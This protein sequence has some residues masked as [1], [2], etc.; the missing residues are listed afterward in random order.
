MIRKK[1]HLIALF[2]A[3]VITLIPLG[4]S[5]A[6]VNPANAPE[7]FNVELD[8]PGVDLYQKDYPYGNPDYVQV[9]DLG[10]GASVRILHT[11]IVNL[12]TGNGVYGG[13]NPGFKL[14]PIQ[15]TWEEFAANDTGAFCITNGGYFAAHDNPTHLAFPIKVGGEIVSDGYSNKA[16]TNDKAMLELWED[17][18]DI[19]PF[20]PEAFHDSTAPDIFTGLS[21]TV[22]QV[23]ED[24]IG[25]TV[26]GVGD[27]D[28]DGIYEKVY[29]FN[30]KTARQGDAL[31]VLESFG[32]EKLMLLE[33]GEFSQLVCEGKPLIM[34]NNELPQTIA[35]SDASSSGF[36]P[37]MGGIPGF[38]AGLV[39][40]PIYPILV[41]GESIDIK[42]EVENTGKDVW[43]PND[44]QLVSVG[45]SLGTERVHELP[46]AVR[47]GEALNF[48][49][50]TEE[51]DRW[52]IY[53]A[54]WFL[55]CGGDTFPQDGLHVSV[56]V[57][58]KQLKDQKE[59]LELK[60][61]EWGQDQL[62]NLE[63]MILQWI[64]AQLDDAIS[65]LCSTPLIAVPMA[66]AVFYLN[67]KRKRKKP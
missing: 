16:F 54:D 2:S 45:E 12:G 31:E 26:I 21:S 18:A 46:Y 10:K 43:N 67:L 3:L 17:H 11:E 44:C 61:H 40:G 27:D 53:S 55:S 36:T 14:Q 35:V 38:D 57:I 25:R 41:E 42:I 1:I 56:I 6:R 33:G 19:R 4:G 64:E 28:G 65:G 30:S 50:Q 47:P 13:D 15:E 63:G 49:W 7:D 60:I 52:G 66:G 23:P 8:A 51:F 48:S 9:A 29:I 59:E 5:S 62:E 34:T 32:A 39:N 24:F 20:T 37:G 58:P 22:E